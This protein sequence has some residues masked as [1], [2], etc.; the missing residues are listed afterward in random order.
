MAGQL[1]PFDRLHCVQRRLQARQP[2]QTRGQRP[3]VTRPCR[4]QRQPRQQPLQIEYSAK[5]PANLLS[6]HQVPMRLR[7]RLIA[8]LQS[9][10]IGQRTQDRRPQ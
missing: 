4:I 10:R 7:D 3:H 2:T 1:P 9:L 5:G 8:C 6:P